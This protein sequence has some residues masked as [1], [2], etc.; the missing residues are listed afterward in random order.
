[1]LKAWDK[2]A[3]SQSWL[4]QSWYSLFKDNSRRITVRADLNQ[5][6]GKLSKMNFDQLYYELEKVRDKYSDHR[7]PDEINKAKPTWTEKHIQDILDALDKY[8]EAY[9][10]SIQAEIDDISAATQMTFL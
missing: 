9:T 4:D 10:E 1:M 7:Y 3:I 8:Q 2:L 5:L 6:K